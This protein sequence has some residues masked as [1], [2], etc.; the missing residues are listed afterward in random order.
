MIVS[1]SPEGLEQD[2]R[3]IAFFFCVVHV[4]LSRCLIY[5]LCTQDRIEL[6][7]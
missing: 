5:E 4:I 3:G 6:C 2:Q 1:M 7:L